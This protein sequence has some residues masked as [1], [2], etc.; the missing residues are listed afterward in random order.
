VPLNP[1]LK[2]IMATQ[3]P[4]CPANLIS[5]SDFHKLQ[6]E[7]LKRYATTG[8]ATDTIKIIFQ[9][10]KEIPYLPRAGFRFERDRLKARHSLPEQG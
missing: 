2:D 1:D 3:Q 6:Q 7:I 10:E 4:S 5:E 8:G 9:P